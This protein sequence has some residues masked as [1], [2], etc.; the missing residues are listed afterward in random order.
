MKNIIWIITGLVLALALFF[1]GKNAGKNQVQTAL[2][3]NISIIKEIAELAGLEV[4]GKTQITI[5]NAGNNA[6]I[7]K[8]LKNYFAENTLKLSVPYQAKY[9]V[10]MGSQQIKIDTEKKKVIV[11][12]PHAKLLSLQLKLDEV[13]ALSKTGLLYS[14]S[15]EEYIL[16]QKQ[17]YKAANESLINNQ[18]HIKLAEN[19]IRFILEKYYQPLGFEVTCVFGNDAPF[20]NLP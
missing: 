2:V 8:R 13:D 7:W 16:A 17:L 14:S 3:Q 15:F 11:Y 18:N 19:H 12:L 20:L 5:S 6:G 10:D 4:D 1:I 9:G